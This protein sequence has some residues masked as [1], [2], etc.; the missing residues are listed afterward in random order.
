M[1][2]LGGI[3]RRS[4][5]YS[6][7][8]RTPG[9]SQARLSEKRGACFGERSI[10]SLSLLPVG[11]V[12]GGHV[13]GKTRENEWIRWVNSWCETPLSAPLFGK[14]MFV[15]KP[16]GP[17]PLTFTRCWEP[18]CLGGGGRDC[19]DPRASALGFLSHVQEP[20]GLRE[21]PCATCSSVGGRDQDILGAL[22][23]HVSADTQGR[24]AVNQG[25]SRP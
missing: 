14:A 22:F 24:R 9:R 8:R 3:S 18:G 1:G 4:K 6:L 17:R 25:A 12:V 2:D 7:F 20:L 23:I 21:E 10:F 19:L 5:Y 15:L 13:V 16:S 11:R